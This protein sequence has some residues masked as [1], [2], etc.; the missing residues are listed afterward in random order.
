MFFQNAIL[1]TLP[2][3]RR[4]SYR[5]QTLSYIFYWLLAS[6]ATESNDLRKNLRSMFFQNA[7]LATLP[8]IKRSSY[9]K[10][11]LSYILLATGFSGYRIESSGKKLH[12]M[13]FQNV[14]LASL[15]PCNRSNYIKQTLYYI[16]LAT[17]FSGY[18]IESDRKKCA[19]SVFS[20]CNAGNSTY[21]LEKQLYKTN[22]I[23]YSHGYWHF[24]LPNRIL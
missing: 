14:M 17:G 13:F 12:S 1:A 15:P 7:I 19:L 5:K 16:L 8:T 21:D 18:R 2:T 10:Q 6:L 3:I 20:K 24:W 9:R 23:L 11:T 4:S 22:T